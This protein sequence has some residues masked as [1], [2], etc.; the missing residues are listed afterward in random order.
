M[1]QWL[2]AVVVFG[3]VM[4]AIGLEKEL[5]KNTVIIASLNVIINIFMISKFGILGAAVTTT[6]MNYVGGLLLIRK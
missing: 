1:F 3:A 4:G 6:V 5:F 2:R